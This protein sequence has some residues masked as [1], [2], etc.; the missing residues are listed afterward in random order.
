MDDNSN[1]GLRL[2]RSK[3]PLSE[4]H[5]AKSMKAEMSDGA[6]RQ[7]MTIPSNGSSQRK[8]EAN[9]RNAKKSTGPKTPPGKTISSWNSL[10]HGLVA[11]RLVTLNEKDGKEFSDLLTALRQDL[12]PVGVLEELLVEKIAHEYWKTVKSARY[13]TEAV[14]D[15]YLGGTTG[16]NLVRYLTMINRQLFQAMNQLERLQRVRKTDVL[17]DTTGAGQDENPGQ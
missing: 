6:S 10:K 12:E 14:Y 9:R 3:Q 11:K 2:G 17:C 13:D 4:S 8:I 5:P 7:R 1:N 15:A 16:G